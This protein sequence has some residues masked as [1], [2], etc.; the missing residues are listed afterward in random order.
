MAYRFE[1][2]ESVE[3]GTRRLALEQ[4]GKA[5]AHLRSTKGDRE[6]HIHD[7]RKCMKRLRGLVRLVRS[8]L[9]EVVYRRENECYRDVARGLGELR[10]VVALIEAVDDLVIWLG[11]RNP[12]SRFRSVRAWL[13]E[14]R[15]IAYEKHGAEDSRVERELVVLGEAQQRVSSWPLQNDGFSSMAGGLSRVYGRGRREYGEACWRPEA[16]V[17]HGWRKRVKYLWYH[18]QLLQGAWPSVMRVT[19]DELDELGDILGRDHDLAVLLKAVDEEFP[20]SGTT[21]TVGALKRRIAERRAA[22]H[23]QC[24]VLGQRCFAERPGAFVR[25]MQA[26]WLS[27]GEEQIYQAPGTERVA[28]RSKDGRVPEASPAAG[29]TGN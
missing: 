15:A 4:I 28:Q 29:V 5:I 2:G 9:G 20:R 24:L 16:S 26:Y 18:L 6:E 12:R 23:N 22:L 25:R 8:E 19:E 17:M 21:A 14:R 7:S 3:D 13:N 1:L 27:W 10:D 11:P